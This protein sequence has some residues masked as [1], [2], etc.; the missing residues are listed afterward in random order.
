VQQKV[1]CRHTASPQGLLLVA[2]LS[3]AVQGSPASKSPFF[4]ILQKEAFAGSLAACTHAASQVDVQQLG[5]VE[6]MRPQQRPFLQPGSS[7]S[8][9]Q[10]PASSRPHALAQRSNALATHIVSQFSA[11]Q[12]GS[13]RQTESQQYGSSQYGVSWTTRQSPLQPDPQPTGPQQYSRAKPAQFESHVWVQQTGSMLQ[14]MAQHEA[15]AQPGLSWTSVHSPRQGQGQSEPVGTLHAAR[16]VLAQSASH[17]PLQHAGSSAHTALQQAGS[18][19]PGFGW[20]A[21]QSPVEGQASGAT[22]TALAMSTQRASQSEVQ[23]CGSTL[24]TA[25]LQS[26]FAQPAEA[27]GVRQPSRPIVTTKPWGAHR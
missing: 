6:Q 25:R 24:H 18:W 16:A 17:A 5:S 9:Q 11:Q 12:S 8:A 20:L 3:C 7:C 21:K 10:L 14:T 26:A 22:Q 4:G 15:S 23:H 1:S 13:A 2:G 19:H 27:C